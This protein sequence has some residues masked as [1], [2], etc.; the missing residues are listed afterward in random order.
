MV[1]VRL[2]VEENPD[3][4]DVEAEAG[5]ARQYERWRAGIAAVYQDVTLGSGDEEGRYVVGADILQISGDAERLGRLLAASVRICLPSGTQ[6]RDGDGDGT[7]HHPQPSPPGSARRG[8]HLLCSL[9]TVAA[10]DEL[11]ARFS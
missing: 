5:D 9:C 6:Y 8:S 4:A 3:V 2:R 10:I 11:L 7:E 1:R